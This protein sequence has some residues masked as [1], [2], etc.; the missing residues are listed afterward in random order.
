[1]L[2]T[3]LKAGTAPAGGNIEFVGATLNGADRPRNSDLQLGVPIGVQEGDL[4][5]AICATTQNL[6]R[7]DWTTTTEWTLDRTNFGAGLY[8]KTASTGEPSSYSF[9]NTSP[10]RLMIGSMLAYRG[11]D[12]DVSGSFSESSTPPGVTVS[13]DGSLLVG[14]SAENSLSVLS[15]P[16][17]MTTRVYGTAI[18]GALV[19]ADEPVDAGL[20]GSRTFSSGTI[21]QLFSM[22]PKG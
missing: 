21:S 22:K 6:G 19:A 4:L 14:F 1:M 17:S 3:R 9:F 2:A 12:F 15:P 7:S 16:A 20:T 13:E 10:R 18:S 8:Y 11:A 5:I